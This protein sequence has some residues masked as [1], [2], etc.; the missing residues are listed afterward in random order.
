MIIIIKNYYKKSK[1]SWTM[2]LSSPQNALQAEQRRLIYI[3]VQIECHFASI[4]IDNRNFYNPTLAE[5][6]EMIRA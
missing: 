6:P 4:Y 5:F 3:E 1:L 2:L